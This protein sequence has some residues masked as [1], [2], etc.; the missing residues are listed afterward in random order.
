MRDYLHADEHELARFLVIKQPFFDLTQRQRQWLLAWLW[1]YQ[2]SN[3]LED[4]FVLFLVITID[5]TS[6]LGSKNYQS[7]L[8]R[9]LLQQLVDRWIRDAFGRIED[10]VSFRGL[11]S[12][13]E[14]NP[15]SR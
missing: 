7:V 10:A 3:E 6:A 9:N 1:G 4:T 5:L 11:G 8:R 12:H 14:T 15:F 13:Y 2:W